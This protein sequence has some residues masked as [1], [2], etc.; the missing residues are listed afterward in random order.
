[1][2]LCGSGCNI[3][4]VC[5]DQFYCKYKFQLQSLITRVTELCLQMNVNAAQDQR[6]SGQQVSVRLTVLLF[7][8]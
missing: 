6:G 3:V 1:M 4:Q 2:H 5:A 8:I 7:I